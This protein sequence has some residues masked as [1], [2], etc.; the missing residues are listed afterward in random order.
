MNILVQK[1][2]CSSTANHAVIPSHATGTSPVFLFLG[3]WSILHE[4]NGDMERLCYAQH[5]KG[6]L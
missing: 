2:L 3:L 6:C 1:S 5:Q 4:G